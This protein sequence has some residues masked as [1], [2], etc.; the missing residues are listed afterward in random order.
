MNKKINTLSMDSSHI[1]IQSLETK[2]L[3]KNI[4]PFDLLFF[5][6][7]SVISDMIEFTEKIFRGN[8]EFS[9]VAIVV[10][11]QIMPCLNVC[12]DDTLYLFE[13]TIDNAV[14][15]AETG[16]IKYGVQIRNM[17]KVI[18]SYN[19]AVY[20]AKLIN[21]PIIKLNH[22]LGI[23]Y[24]DRINNLKMIMNNLHTKYIND[25]YQYNICRLLAPFLPYCYCLRS[26]CC[27]G[28]DEMFCSELVS[29]VYTNIGVKNLIKYEKKEG[30]SNE[31]MLPSDVESNMIVETP[32][33]IK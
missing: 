23:V 14:P 24:H 15:D 21:N 4:K 26:K 5:D 18:N 10:N 9:H 13:S 27:F 22:E 32:I 33:Q 2:I 16:N 30:Y 20:W 17:N 19:G 3:I 25:T 1:S 11:K 31:T 28:K 12:N 29:I 6:G 8:G 7:S